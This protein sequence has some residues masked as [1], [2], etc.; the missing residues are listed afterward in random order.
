MND[1]HASSSAAKNTLH[2]AKTTTYLYRLLALSALTCLLMPQAFATHIVGGE[3]TYTC[4]GDDMYE[5]NL[6]IY[7]DCFYGNPQA[8]FDDPASIG[9]FDYNNQLI[10]EILVPLM[11]DDTLQQVLTDECLVVPPTVCVHTTTY[12]T[13]VELPPIIGGYQIAYQRC[14]RNQTIQNI[15]DPLG[16]GATF[17]VTITERALLECNSSANFLQWPPLY[18]CANHPIIFDQSAT[19]IDGDSIVYRLCTPLQGATP[20]EPMPQPP[21]APP[22]DQVN[23]NDPPYN[24]DNMLNGIPGGE[25]LA[26][27]PITGLLTGTPTT[28]GQF[29]VGIC[30]EEYRDGEL[31]ATVRRDFQYNVGICGQITAAFFAPEIQ[32]DGL[33]VDFDNESIGADSYLWFF[34]GL[35][36]L[37]GTDTL[38]S[39]SFVFPDTGWYEVALIAEPGEFCAD[40]FYQQIQ[41]LPNSLMPSFEIDTLACGDSLWLALNDQ[42]TDHVSTPVSWEWTVN[43]SIFSSMP[44]T[45]I[46]LTEAGEYEIELTVTAANGCEKMASFTIDA[47]AFIQEQ[48][49]ADTL[50]ICPGDSIHLNSSFNPNYNY[51]WSPATFLDDATSPNPLATP[52]EST[53][54]SVLITD[55]EGCSVERSMFLAVA[56]PIVAELTPDTTS[57]SDTIQLMVN[58]NTGIRYFWATNINFSADVVEGPINNVS[59]MG[60]QDYYVLVFDETGCQYVDSVSV[61]IQAV[62]IDLSV[63]DTAL[64]LDTPLSLSAT[65]LDANDQNTITW[66]P[67]SSILSGQNS[68]NIEVATNTVGEQY[69]SYTAMNQHGCEKQDS[70][71]LTVVDTLQLTSDLSYQQCSGNRVQFSS[72]HPYAHL[73]EWHFGDPFAPNASAVGAEV[74][75]TYFQA[76]TY[77]AYLT[78]PEHL[79]CWDTL[80]LAVEVSED[81]PIAAGFSWSYASCADTALVVLTNETQTIGTNINS[82]EWWLVDSLLIGTNDTETITVYDNEELEIA[83]ITAA[84]NGCLDTFVSSIST[85]IIPFELVDSLSLC[86]GESVHLYPSASVDYDY[87]WSPSTYLDNATSANPLASPNQSTTYNV[88]V[89]DPNSVCERQG[90]VHVAVAP[91]IVYELPSDTIICEENILLYANTD[92]DIDIEWGVNNSFNPV[93]SEEA[94][95]STAVGASPYFYIRLTD[96]YN[97][98][99]I[100][101]VQVNSHAIQLSLDVEQTICLGD[102][103]DI[104][105]LATGG[106]IS[107]EWTPA[108]LIVGDNTQANISV[109]A[110]TDTTLLLQLSNEYGCDLDTSVQVNIF[111]FSPPLEIMPVIDTI[112]QGES[113]Q[114]EATDRPGY[115]YSWSPATTLSEADVYNPIASPEET[116]SYQLFITDANGCTNTASATVVIFDS[117]CIRPYVFVPNVFSP[118]GD[119]LNDTWGIEAYAVESLHIEVYNRWGEKIFESNDVNNRWDGSFEGKALPPDVYGYYVELKCI[120]GE[121]FVEKGNV[122]LMR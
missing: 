116:T 78:L 80:H 42:S 89:T 103:L 110:T 119:L 50:S 49:P 29:V 43:D 69:I 76:G 75:Y 38:E 60:M 93:L 28:L 12:T 111:D 118:N 99:T 65:N 88:F 67:A 58:S 113:V 21:N 121:S 56:P 1:D 87:Q 33:E 8:Y 117:P 68:M 30:A 7:R 31:I 102:T 112:L 10:Q 62:D 35:D 22:Y 20:N 84:D 24:V 85:H 4:L 108:D 14:C 39:P 77:N 104:T 15:I 61:N 100:D 81:T 101:S 51:Q 73:Y 2:L 53:N 86:A 82:I 74:S 122:S 41:L 6:V 91:P 18:I 71:R 55:E 64:C 19:D 98:T 9:V 37:L 70:I 48:L 5:L 23:W 96:E 57:C 94:E 32:C 3:L 47:D 63:R 92:A 66:M 79:N 114:L 52:Q 34:G 40:T 120:G 44:N 95:W 106:N 107:Y 27:D 16:T 115:T 109:A 59:P 97:C 54:Y 26:I 105:A 13:T 45:E 36:N 46:V 25:L 17:G 11:G 72:Q 83:L 90:Q